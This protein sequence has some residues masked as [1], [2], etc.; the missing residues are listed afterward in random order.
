MRNDTRELLLEVALELFATKGYHATKVSNIVKQAGV[1]QGTFYWHFQSKSEIAVTI[2]EDGKAKLLD[3]IREGYRRDIGNVSDML[4]S[5]KNLVQHLFTYANHNRYLMI[6]L[7]QKGHGGDEPLRKAVSE[8][9][10]AIEAEFANN[11]QRAIDLNMLANR[12]SVDLQAQILTSF[13][14]GIL[15]RWLFGP[16]NKLDHTP[17]TSID[18]IAEEIVRYEFFGLIGSGGKI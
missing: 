3:V 9:I 6:L 8:T 14:T 4:Q 12:D 10:M 13:F 17:N 15:S 2:M 1:A 7:F 5:S 18:D 16:L 11:I